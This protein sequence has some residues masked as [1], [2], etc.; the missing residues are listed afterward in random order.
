MVCSNKECDVQHELVRPQAPVK[1]TA[2]VATMGT[3]VSMLQN[4]QCHLDCLAK[5]GRRSVMHARPPTASYKAHLSTG[6]PLVAAR[7]PRRAASDGL[8]QVGAGVEEVSLCSKIVWNKMV[9]LFFFSTST[10]T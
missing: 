7:E 2:R 1:Y 8:P 9:L 10:S 5:C 3:A 4:A 6:D